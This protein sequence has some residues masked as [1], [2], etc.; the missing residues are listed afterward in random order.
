M[1]DQAA[2]EVQAEEKKEFDFDFE[3]K[4]GKVV[5]VA[6]Y[7]GKGLESELVNKVHPEYFLEKL[8]KLIP[9]EVDDKIID[10]LKVA[11]KLA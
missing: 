9:G 11:L 5:M 3:L 4:D 8:K 1:V 6:K 2:A 10:F 7:S